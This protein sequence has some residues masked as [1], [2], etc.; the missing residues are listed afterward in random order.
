VTLRA[1]RDAGFRL[2]ELR[3]YQPWQ[4]GPSAAAPEPHLLSVNEYRPHRLRDLAPIAR[5]SAELAG[6]MAEMDDVCG[7][8]TAYDPLRRI[9]YSLS[10]WKSDEA[11]RTFTFSPL[12]R[13]VMANYRSRGYLRHIH[14]WGRFSS[15]G[16]GAAEATDRLDG[17]QGR[18]VGE[19]RDRWARQDRRRLD[20][21]RPGSGDAPLAAS[22]SGR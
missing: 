11:L 12:H 19:T 10:I 9:T 20:Q 6:Q 15:I 21:L 17:G 18:R 2:R 22:P 4:P 16:A 3:I 5:I 1:H 8:A 13:E 14:W 7:I